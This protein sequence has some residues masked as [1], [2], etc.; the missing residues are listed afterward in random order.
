MNGG[1]CLF[2]SSGCG[3]T[4]TSPTGSFTSP[5]YPE[6]YGHNAVC[7]YKITVSRG[8]KIQLVLVD[9]ELEES[10]ECRFDYIEVRDY[11]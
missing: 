3:G 1:N 10:S 9:L 11:C 6:T 5:N 7:T 2:Y 8:S 4:L